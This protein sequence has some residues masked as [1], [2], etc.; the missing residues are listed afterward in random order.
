MVQTKD[1]IDE[2][3][4]DGET[5]VTAWSSI[6]ATRDV[7]SSP[8]S[9]HHYYWH[10]DAITCYCCLATYNTYITALSPSLHAA[11][12]KI[13]RSRV[14]D[15]IMTMTINILHSPTVFVDL[16]ENGKQIG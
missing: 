3:C 7:S 13:C 8:T 1:W 15:L 2:R 5:K 4:S 10:D 14:I 6:L 11:T 9:M 16:F 12:C